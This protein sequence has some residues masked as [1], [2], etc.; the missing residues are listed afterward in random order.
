MHAIKL[1]RAAR[2]STL[3]RYP[4]TWAALIARIPPDVIATVTSRQ[5]AALAAAMHAQYNAGH[6]AGWQD[7]R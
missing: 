2:L 1:R 6:T 7:M 4:R 3:S 5:I